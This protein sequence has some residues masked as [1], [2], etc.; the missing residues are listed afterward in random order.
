LHKSIPLNATTPRQLS[1]IDSQLSARTH[2]HGRG[3]GDGLALG[4]ALGGGGVGDPGELG[5]GVT[6]GVA[7][8]GGVCVAEGDGVGGIVAVG[9]AEGVCVGVGV[10]DPGEL[11]VGV[12]DGVP[13]P[14]TAARISIRPQPN[15]LFGGPAAPHCVL[16]INTAVSFRASRLA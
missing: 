10:G 9:V 1:T 16:E 3:C 5:V 7:V 11:G 14:V 4:V 12:G 8:D 6:V 2:L 15:T 13:P